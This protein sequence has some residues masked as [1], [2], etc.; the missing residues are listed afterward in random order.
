MG[1][2]SKIEWTD[3]L[4]MRFWS[5]VAIGQP[6]ECWEWK[7]GCFDNGYGQFRLGDRKVKANRC[8]YELAVGPLG[9]LLALHECDNPPCCNPAHLFAGTPADNSR[10]RNQKGRAAP[11]LLKPM[12]GEENPA[13]KLCFGQVVEI[14]AMSQ[15]G[16]SQRAIAQHFGISQ[17]Q[18]GNIVRG[19]SW[20]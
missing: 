5:Y 9:D 19:S 6:N 17:S 16:Y 2:K 3:E 7:G 14:R 15:S 18:V 8:A 4:R 1:D 12:R 20:A 11:C 10:D 13:A